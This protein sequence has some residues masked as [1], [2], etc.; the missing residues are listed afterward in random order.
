MDEINVELV[1]AAINE[2][3]TTVDEQ[4]RHDLDGILCKFKSDYNCLPTVVTCMRMISS[5]ESSPNV[6]YF[7]TVC[8]YDV[9]RLRSD[10]CVSDPTIQ[11]SVKSFLIESLT[12]GTYSQTQSVLNKLSSTLAILSLYCIPDLWTEPVAD[13][14]SLW[15]PTPELLLKV[16]SDIAAE[17][18]NVTMP[19]AQRSKL[20]T[21]LHRISNDI[22]KI[23]WTVLSCGDATASTKRA[24]VDCVEQWIRLPGVALENWSNVLSIVLESVAK[25]C[26]ALT[27]LLSILSENDELSNMGPLVMDICKYII[28]NVSQKVGEELKE[29]GCSEE[30]SSLVSATCC[31]AER[32]VQTLVEVSSQA[33][34]VELLTKMLDFMQALSTLPGIYPIDEIVSDL[35]VV[36]LTTLREEVVSSMSSQS[37]KN[38]S[39]VVENVAP[40]YAQILCSSIEK[41]SYPEAN[42][43]ERYSKEDQDLFDEYRT[44]R[45][46]VSV[47]SYLLSGSQTLAFLNTKLEESL[48]ANLNYNRSEAILYLWE[49]VGDY[50]N[51]K[52]YPNILNFLQIVVQHFKISPE[53]ALINRDQIRRAN[54]IMKV[55]YTLSHL[56]QAHDEVIQLEIAIIPVILSYLERLENPKQ[57]LIT[58]EKFLEDRSDCLNNI[59]DSILSTC[60]NFFNNSNNWKYHRLTALKCIGYV[61]S[62]KKSSE[63][64]DIIYRILNE[65]ITKDDVEEYSFSVNIFSSLFTSLRKKQD[66][67]RNDQEEEDPAIVIIL[68][69][70]I[71]VFERIY[72]QQNDFR[73][74]GDICEAVRNGLTSLPDKYIPDFFPFVVQ[75]LNSALFINAQSACS[76]AKSA[77][78][79]CGS[80]V[81]IELANSIAGWCSLFEQRVD[82]A[83]MEEWLAL[84]YQVFKKDWKTIRK[85]EE[86][87]I[88]A[89]K[90][91]LNI[92][93]Y[94]IVHSAEPAVVRTASQ[95]LACIA[96]Q[97]TIND[98][99]IVKDILAKHGENLVKTIFVRVQGEL[100]RQTVESLAEVLF[101]Y[102]KQ[103][104]TET[105]QVILNEPYGNTPLVAAM[106]RDIGNLRNFKQMTLRFNCATLNDRATSTSR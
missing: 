74:I 100:M 65:H 51:E 66:S 58:L 42:I 24:A 95:T 50:T 17:F 72:N 89:I 8:L 82:D 85:F 2:F 84:L 20:K 96:S 70:A 47:D 79:Q 77:V 19:L 91:A 37:K 38:W 40:F 34:N 49:C 99:N 54:T 31:L 6:R 27:N 61:L 102:F 105:R 53:T 104:T 55:L 90:S 86:P 13:L 92:C 60:Y 11:I 71:P 101:F 3:Y 21:E 67:N 98:D 52:D 15:A 59:G 39:L 9:I 41:L 36:F 14:T 32:A 12:S 94:T 87:F 33:G 68:R 48:T 10:E 83:Q 64:M 80:L 22:I 1:I 93:S 16:L 29:D 88:N 78:L 46:E 75:L 81:G 18:S 7:A 97:T 56:I 63:T 35:P 45:S 57:V 26:T 25:D 106:F 5:S 4:R 23:I 76:L 30:V 44:T 73:L 28:V 43:F 103:F 69:E 62:K